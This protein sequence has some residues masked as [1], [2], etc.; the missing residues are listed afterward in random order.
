MSEPIYYEHFAH[1]PLPWPER[2]GRWTWRITDGMAGRTLAEGVA[3]TQRG[4]VRKQ[5]AAFGRCQ[6]R[7]PYTQEPR[8]PLTVAE[9]CWICA[10]LGASGVP[11]HV[12]VRGPAV[13]ITPLRTLSTAQEV[14]ALNAVLDRTDAPVRWAGVA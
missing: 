6:Q 2:V 5:A 7:A 10:V 8:H 4:A 11:V 1:R 13:V 9:A 3:L 12:D 14:R